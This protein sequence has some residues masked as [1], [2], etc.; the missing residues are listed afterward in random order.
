MSDLVD[1]FMMTMDTI[2]VVPH[3]EQLEEVLQQALPGQ[4]ILVVE[5]YHPYAIVTEDILRPLGPQGILMDYEEHFFFP[6]LT[7]LGTPV[8]QIALGMLAD[9]DVRWHVIMNQGHAEGI[10]PPLAVTPLLQATL[11]HLEPHQDRSI[12]SG[13]GTQLHGNPLT[14]PVSICFHCPKNA[15][16]HWPLAEARQYYDQRRRAICPHDQSILIRHNPC[17]EAH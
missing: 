4:V 12:G 5:D 13:F 11:Q 6:T 15:S 1:Y 3:T 10:L 9:P 14:Q 17:P 7:S 2:L 16:H 8:V